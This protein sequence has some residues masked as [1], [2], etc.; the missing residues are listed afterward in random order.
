MVCNENLPRED[1]PHRSKIREGILDSWASEFQK[2]KEW[3]KV[4]SEHVIIFVT[5]ITSHA[6]I[7][8]GLGEGII[9]CR[10]LVR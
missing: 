1:I 5:I 7:L 8:V 6:P 4:C 3:L 9:Y 2:L 10:Y